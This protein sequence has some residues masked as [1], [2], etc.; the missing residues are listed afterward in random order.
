MELEG[1]P[2]GKVIGHLAAVTAAPH[3]R[4]ELPLPL[5]SEHTLGWGSYFVYFG[6]RTSQPARARAFID[7]VVKRLSL[8]VRVNQ[9]TVTLDCDGQMWRVA[10]ELLRHLVDV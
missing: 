4:S 9:H 5:L 6:S 10:F 7:L 2:S 8:I 1:R 3:I